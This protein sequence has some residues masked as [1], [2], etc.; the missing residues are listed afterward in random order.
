M[1]RPWE[2]AEVIAS[3]TQPESKSGEQLYQAQDTKDKY[4]ML[5]EVLGLAFNRAAKGKGKERHACGEPFEKQQIIEVSKRLQGHPA[6]G[7]LF[8][9]VKKIY[10]SK[11]LDRDAAIDE[12]ADA[13]VYTAAAIIVIQDK[14]G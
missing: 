8:Q 13:I 9:A 12:L 5:S 14:K 11:R 7:P 1:V 3:K 6:A 2:K 4:Y 10:E